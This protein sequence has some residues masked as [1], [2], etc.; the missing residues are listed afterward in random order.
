MTRAA[1]RGTAGATEI[2]PPTTDH[3]VNGRGSFTAS[4]GSR[5]AAPG[6]RRVVTLA[7]AGLA[8]VLVVVTVAIVVT[9][10]G[11]T[12]KRAGA[13]V[14]ATG[15]AAR[16]GQIP[17]WLPKAKV[18]VGRIV[19]ASATHPALGIEGDTIAVRLAVGRLLATAVGPQVPE[20]GQFPV[21]RTTRCNFIVTFARASAS[22]ALPAGAFTIVDEYGNV[23][24]PRVAAYAGG[25][26]PTR[27]APGRTVSLVVS[28]VLPTGSG[29]LSW[30]PETTKPIASWDFDVEID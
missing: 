4:G 7:L 16:Y 17:S 23:H 29:E 27:V 10:G 6:S 15:G 28:D 14:A 11:S 18:S 26:A 24:R 12:H 25:A 1:S 8:V 9:R 13:A 5:A 21:P 19:E 30:A 2:R 3:A 20:E 22:I